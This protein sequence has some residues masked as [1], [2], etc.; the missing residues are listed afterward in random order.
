[1]GMFTAWDSAVMDIVDS[2]T[3]KVQDLPMPPFLAVSGAGGDPR[4]VK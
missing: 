3:M 2:K 4:G 1:M